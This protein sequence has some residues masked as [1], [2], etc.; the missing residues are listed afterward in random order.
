MNASERLVAVGVDGCRG[1]WVAAL[2]FEASGRKPR[3]ELKRFRT[4]AEL[5]R[6]RETHP[7]RP[8]VAIDVPI[9]LPAGVGYRP[10]DD[11][12]RKIL[13]ERW[14][15]VFQAPDRG[16]FQHTYPEVQAEIARRRETDPEVRGLSKQGHGIMDKVEEVDKL[17]RKDECREKWLVEVH[18]EVSFRYLADTDMPPKKRSPGRTARLAVLEPEFPDVAQRY[19]E[20][21]WLRREV[22]RD[23][24]L[25]A[26]AGLWSARRFARR[27]AAC[28]ELGA[29]ERDD[30]GVLM[31]MVV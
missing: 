6:W 14:A 17:A 7:D 23:D 18:P 24:I 1:G 29:G 3:T 28:R 22:G 19:E 30:R 25:D 12:A 16:L 9:G 21:L 13:G 11:E 31:R 2:C 26:Y 27:P 5:V 20:K 10:C 4:A 8:V 15:C